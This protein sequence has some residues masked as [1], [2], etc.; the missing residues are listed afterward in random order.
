M[1]IIV[2]RKLLL[3]KFLI[4]ITKFTDQGILSVNKDYID[5]VSNTSQDKQTVILYT[6]LVVKTDMTEDNIKLNVGDLK[7]LISALSCINQDIIKLSIEKNHIAY[8]SPETNF[9]F[10]LKEDGTINTCPINMEKI[11][12]IISDTEFI[13]S[14]EKINELIKASSFCVDSNKVY[15]SLKDGK[16]IAEL[17]D[18]TIQNLDAITINLTDEIHGKVFTDDIIFKLDIF[19]LISSL[20]FDKLSV[21]LTNKGAVIFEIKDDNYLMKYIASGLIK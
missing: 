17:T 11:N 2:D 3:S 13:I 6:K 12:A 1:D 7:K 20:K 18:K 8:Q 5:C 14:S 10:H 9:K 21:K 4:P 19:K 16:L 15:L